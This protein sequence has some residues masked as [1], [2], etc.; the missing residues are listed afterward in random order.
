M[1]RLA[2]P[3]VLVGMSAAT[4][5]ISMT[6]HGA[7][8]PTVS[9]GPLLAVGLIVVAIVA[10]ALSLVGHGTV[11]SVAHVLARVGVD[12]SWE[13]DHRVGPRRCEALF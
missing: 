7:S 12:R 2:L 13:L 4:G 9:P 11:A 1:R 6:T 5:V 8:T 3:V 10:C